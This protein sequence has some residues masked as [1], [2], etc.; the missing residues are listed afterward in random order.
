MLTTDL[1]VRMVKSMAP[2]QV[3]GGVTTHG[4]A[5][6]KTEEKWQTTPQKIQN[7]IFDVENEVYMC[8]YIYIYVYIYI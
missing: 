5:R 1:A 2:W 3:I 8:I 6:K 4:D 7:L